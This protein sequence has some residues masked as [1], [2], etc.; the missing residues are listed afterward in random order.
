[1][2]SKSTQELAESFFPERNTNKKKA[3]LNKTVI[4]SQKLKVGETK[5]GAEPKKKIISFLFRA[6][7]WADVDKLY[8]ILFFLCFPLQILR[9]NDILHKGRQK[10]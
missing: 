7:I 3:A 8:K 4:G 10:L 6:T 1:M 9:S 2:A 5:T